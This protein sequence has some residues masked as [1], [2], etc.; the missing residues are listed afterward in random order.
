MQTLGEVGKEGRSAVLIY[1]H[2]QPIELRGFRQQE[3]FVGKY[4]IIVSRSVA[5]KT[6][7]QGE[8]I[9]PGYEVGIPQGKDGGVFRSAA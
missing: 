2:G 3:T 6:P 1:Q 8:A 7:V 9:E 5:W 4:G